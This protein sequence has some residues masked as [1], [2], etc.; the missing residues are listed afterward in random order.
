MKRKFAEMTPELVEEAE[1]YIRELGAPA[2][3]PERDEY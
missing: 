3:E 1:D 2:G